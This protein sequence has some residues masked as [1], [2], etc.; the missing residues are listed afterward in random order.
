[1]RRG[2][3]ESIICEFSLLGKVDIVVQESKFIGVTV[4]EN[5]VLS[6]V[7]AVISLRDVRFEIFSD[8]ELLHAF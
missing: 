1:V 2:G 6:G 3:L 7:K 8:F 4:T 5:R